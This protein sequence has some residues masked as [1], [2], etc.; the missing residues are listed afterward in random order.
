MFDFQK[1][2]SLQK[3]GVPVGIYSA[4]TANRYVIKAVLK[5]AKETNTCALIEATANQVNQDGGYTGQT[6]EMFFRFVVDLA[7]QVGLERSNLILGGDHLGPLTWASLPEDEAMEKAETLVA[8]FVRAGFTK[9]HL[10]T[11]M[12]LGSDDPNVTLETW[13]IAR[14]GAQLCQAA[15]KA[16]NALKRERP[17][18]K[19]PVYIIG[20]EVPIPG[21]AQEE[22][23]SIS[24]TRAE[25]CI[26]TISEFKRAFFEF[27][28]EDAWSRVI[29]LVVQPGVEFGNDRVFPFDPAAASA[30]TDALRTLPVVFEGHS[31]DYQTAASLRE[32]V[33]SG[34]AILKV[35]PQLT[36]ALREALIAMEMIEI[37]LLT[38]KDVW[39]SG[40][41]RTLE[42]SMLESPKQWEK[43]YHGNGEETRLMRKYSYSDR[44]R[45]Y[46]AGTRVNDSIERLLTNLNGVQ[47]PPSILS[48]F[49]PVQYKKFRD[50]KLPLNAE[51]ILL[52][53]IGE[54][55]DN[56]I[57]ATRSEEV[58]SS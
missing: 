52:D 41:G 25:D 27:G 1:L 47:I 37:E 7:E 53:K 28:M 49:L 33:K 17:A 13:R 58:C 9:I 12:R 32:M 14:R 3:Q 38:G 21:G 16:Y 44:S 6:P 29:G 5:R 23:D 19:P 40:F 31:T 4:C 51:D 2:V 15:E 57:F 36:F 24:I 39:L 34:I 46:L 20:S 10:D 11:S 55:I 22:E 54:V 35:G 43:Y 18:A 56:Y 30:L 26:S 45:Y 48:Q 42:R 50:G 8:A